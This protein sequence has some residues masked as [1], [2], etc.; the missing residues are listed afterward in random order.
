MAAPAQGDILYRNASAW[1]RLP[2]GTSGDVLTTNGAGANPSWTTPSGGTVDVDPAGAL[3]GDGSPGS[4]LAVRVDNSTIIINGSNELEATTGGGGTVTTTGSPASGNL[5]QFSGATSITNG[6]L[7]GDVTTSGTLTTTIANNAVTTAKI[8]NSN[9]TLAKIA[10]AAANDKL[11]GSG[12]AGS[13]NPYAEITLGS[14][15]TMTGTTLSASGS[16][17]NVTTGV[18]LTSG[19]LIVGAGGSAIGV[20][21]LSGDVTTSGGTAA[22][23]KAA[24]KA[25]VISFAIGN[26]VDVI[27]TGWTGLVVEIPY[28]ATITAARAFSIDAN[29]ATS[30]DIEVDVLTTSYASYDTYTSIVASAPIVLSGAIKSED[31]TL[32]GWTTAITAGALMT[33]MVN[34]GDL[35]KVLVS[36]TVSK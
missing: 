3:D 4:P 26:G 8:L 27:S 34:S 30:G 22:T 7:S 21:N 31:T 1:V 6:N 19:Q 12:N 10:N 15:L 35:T 23:A 17:G 14:G 36:L 2:A 29:P 13:G 18:T 20:G 5:T 9:V 24:L 33:V 11:V 32:T 16:G 28:A 25:G